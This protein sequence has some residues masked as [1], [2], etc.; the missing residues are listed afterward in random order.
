[1]AGNK[2]SEEWGSGII[3][4]ISMAKSKLSK[5]LLYWIHEWDT[6]D[7]IHES[8]QEIDIRDLQWEQKQVEED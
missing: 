4:L 1:M 2:E 3:T 6:I 5:A 8:D 7:C